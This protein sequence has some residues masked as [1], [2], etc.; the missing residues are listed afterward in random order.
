MMVSLK[1]VVLTIKFKVFVIYLFERKERAAYF[2]RKL[3]IFS[4]LIAVPSAI[5]YFIYE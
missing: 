2:V 3:Y 4:L 5:D 1:T